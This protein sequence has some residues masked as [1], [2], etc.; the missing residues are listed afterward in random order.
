MA[1]CMNNVAKRMLFFPVGEFTPR[2]DWNGNRNWN[3]VIQGVER[4]TRPFDV[5]P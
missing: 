4:E 2:W 5:K 1:E 3:R